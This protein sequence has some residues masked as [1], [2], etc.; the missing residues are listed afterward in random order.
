[1]HHNVEEF[2]KTMRSFRAMKTVVHFA[3]GHKFHE[4]P[5]ETYDQMEAI[6][7]WWREVQYQKG[8]KHKQGCGE[9]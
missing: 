6:E 1:M 7:Y 4:Q 9:L 5:D 8:K 2:K 3:T